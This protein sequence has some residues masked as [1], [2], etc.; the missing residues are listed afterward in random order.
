[1]VDGEKAVELEAGRRC[2]TRLVTSWRLCRPH[3]ARPSFGRARRAT[4]QTVPP[5]RELFPSP[6]PFTTIRDTDGTYGH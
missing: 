4:I 3:C 5:P 2:R 1:M 6:L